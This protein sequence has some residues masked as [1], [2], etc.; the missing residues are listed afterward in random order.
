[1]GLFIHQC[2]CLNEAPYFF[3]DSVE[4]EPRFKFLYEKKVVDEGLYFRSKIWEGRQPSTGLQDL[5]AWKFDAKLPS[6]AYP[7]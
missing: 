7:K 3:G 1:M 5:G 2:F 4:F 6:P